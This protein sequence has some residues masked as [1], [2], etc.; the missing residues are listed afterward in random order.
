MSKCSICQGGVSQRSWSDEAMT[1]AHSPQTWMAGERQVMCWWTAPLQWTEIS[2]I[3]DGGGIRP[4]QWVQRGRVLVDASS[5]MYTRGTLASTLQS[6]HSVSCPVQNL[7]DGQ[8]PT[9]ELC[10]WR[11]AEWDGRSI[12]SLKEISGVQDT[13][14]WLLAVWQGRGGGGG[15]GG[16]EGRTIDHRSAH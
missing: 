16:M 9:D 15:G 13:A 5:G 12:M 7:Q 1:L 8:Q 2:G 3:W 6:A 14:Q 10:F 11:T 4:T